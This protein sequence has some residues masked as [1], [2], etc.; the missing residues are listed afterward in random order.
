MTPEIEEHMA[1]LRDVSLYVSGGAS[2]S[3]YAWHIVADDGMTSA[4]GIPILGD[5]TMPVSSLGP[6]DYRC[7][8]PGCRVRWPDR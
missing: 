8:R 7:Q 1:A 6:R 2:R 5:E 3:A 4:C